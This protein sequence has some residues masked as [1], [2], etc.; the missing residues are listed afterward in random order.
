MH[1]P[2]NTVLLLYQ[3][4]PFDAGGVVLLSLEQHLRMECLLFIELPPRAHCCSDFNMYMFDALPTP[5]HCLQQ[6]KVLLKTAASL[7]NAPGGIH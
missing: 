1:A 4:P 5:T 3:H 2:V 6:Y 7:S